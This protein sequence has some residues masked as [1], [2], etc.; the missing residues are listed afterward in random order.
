MPRI[1]KANGKRVTSYMDGEFLVI[2]G[3]KKGP[4]EPSCGKHGERR[5]ETAVYRLR[6][7]RAAR[8][9]IGAGIE[10]P[11][12]AVGPGER[13]FD[14]RRLALSATRH[15]VVEAKQRLS[16]GRVRMQLRTAEP[17]LRAAVIRVNIWL[18][19]DEYSEVVAYL[20]KEWPSES[21]DLDRTD[22]VLY[23]E[24]AQLTWLATGHIIVARRD[25]Q[26]SRAGRPSRP[27]V[28]GRPRAAGR[29]QSTGGEMHEA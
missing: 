21:P 17:G 24:L 23:P 4:P 5:V 18:T 15:A 22:A 27:G 12:L 14:A 29:L 8:Q 7:E 13:I 20:E 6:P 9:A 1:G 25:G 2:T 11:L 10:K 19:R 16:D 28:A 26:R 3:G